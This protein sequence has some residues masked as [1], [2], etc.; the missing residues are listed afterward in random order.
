[1]YPI[2]ANAKQRFLEGGKQIARLTMERS[3]YEPYN[4]EVFSTQLSVEGENIFT[5]EGETENKYLNSNG[6]EASSNSYCI[7]D[8]LEVEPLKRYVFDRIDYSVISRSVYHAYYDENKTLI[9]VSPACQE[10]HIPPTGTKYVR[11]SFRKNY[12]PDSVH[13]EIGTVYEG[14]LNV[15]TGVLTVTHGFINDLSHYNYALASTTYSYIFITDY[16]SNGRNSQTDSDRNKGFICSGYKASSS[17]SVSVSFTPYSCL[18]V[19]TSVVLTGNG[20]FYFRNDD[21]TGDATAFRASMAGIQA[22]Y[23]FDEPCTYQLTP[24]E[25]TTLLGKNEIWADSGNISVT[26]RTTAGTETTKTGAI[27]SIPDGANNVPVASLS[28]SIEAKQDLHGYS[29][30]WAGGNGKNKFDIN[31]L[32]ATGITIEGGVASGTAATFH[33]N[34]GGNAG[35]VPISNLPQGQ[36]TLSFDVRTDGNSSTSGYGIVVRFHYTDNTWT[37]IIKTNN[38]TEYSHEVMSSNANKV[39]D[40]IYI[41][42]SSNGSNIW[43]FKNIQLEVGSSETAYEPYA[44]VCP[45]TGYDAVT[46][47]RTGGNTFNA[48]NFVLQS[49]SGLTIEDAN[50]ILMQATSDMEN[51]NEYPLEKGYARTLK[52]FSKSLV[53]VGMTETWEV[54]QRVNGVLTSI[55]HVEQGSGG[56]TV[57]ASV[58]ADADAIVFGGW[59]GTNTYCELQDIRLDIGTIPA[60]LVIT[61][62][63]IIEGGLSVNRYCTTGKAVMVGSV[64]AGEMNVVLNNEDGAFNDV[65]FIGK[66]IKVEVGT[67]DGDTPDYIPLGYFQVDDSPKKLAHISLTTLDRMMLLEKDID[68]TKLEF[69]MTVNNLFS[70]ICNECG[71]TPASGQTLLNGDYEI[72]AYPENVQT[73]RDLLSCIAEISGTCAYF[74]WNGELRLEWFNPTPAVELNTH[75]R[76]SSDLSEESVIITGVEVKASDGDYLAGNDGFLLTVAQNP[77]ITHDYQSVADSLYNARGNFGY[78]PFTANTLPMPYLYPLDTAT[79]VDRNGNES[80]VAITDWTFR[81]NR[82]TDLRGRG[83]STLQASFK[84]KYGLTEGGVSI[85]E[86]IGLL[87]ETIIKNAEIVNQSMEELSRTLHGEYEAI[88]SEFGTYRNET[89]AKI[90]ANAEGITQAYSNIEE[91]DSKYGAAV[92][93]TNQ[94]VLALGDG[95]VATN[96]KFREMTEAYIKSGKLYY[97]GATPVYGVAVGQLTY[98]TVGGEELV[99]RKGVYSVFTSEELAFYID[100]IKVAYMRNRKLYINEAEF[101]SAVKIGRFTLEDGTNGF[102]IK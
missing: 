80:V 52:F 101:V 67:M 59:S 55:A 10:F 60:N 11:L 35:G 68:E 12:A 79:F 31:F 99:K 92:T 33:S 47:T 34:F 93:D 54:Y 86:A 61:E 98:E 30:P 13:I 84:K 96:T 51:K 53:S 6:A 63:K 43:Y 3:P 70:I 62:D 72:E 38:A 5:R 22:V 85:D 64:V 50:T 4:G 90:T 77:L 73:Y 23:P 76:T 102:T 14:T 88:S 82:N 48:N 32:E 17:T 71:V 74:D 27:V 26:Y 1:M 94:A 7:T 91:I 45:I 87:R 78:R 75:N 39:V 16:M 9:R 20:R 89:D 81:L 8:Y 28:A 100:D 40:Y 18:F 37:G 57:V 83:E 15:K 66:D 69:P 49:G 58:S 42:Y 95:A 29:Y 19:G 2:S 41:S 46:V 24:Q 56:R 36:L 25:V 44:N 65:N 21:Y 97:E